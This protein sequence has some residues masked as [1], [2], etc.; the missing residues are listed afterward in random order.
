M[1]QRQCF[2]CY[3]AVPLCLTCVLNSNQQ[4]TCL[5]CPLA[6]YVSS[7]NICEFCSSGCSSCSNS[8]ICL[9]CFNN[10][11]LNNSIC[12]PCGV[13]NCNTCTKS[14]TCSTCSVNYIRNVKGTTCLACSTG[15]SLCTT[16][17]NC[18]L[19][20]LGYYISN[21]VCISCSNNCESFTSK[22]C[23]HC[24]TGFYLTDS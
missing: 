11:F 16:P 8:S 15:C 6:M 12:L 21:G 10:Y 9:T 19:C 1:M 7:K 18:K 5:S 17:I 14:N 22:A 2:S 13:P 23:Q 20:S 4:V 3:E 24:N